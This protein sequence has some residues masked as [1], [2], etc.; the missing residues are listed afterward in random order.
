MNRQF[1]LNIALLLGI[2]G[3]IKPLYLFGI[4][5]TIQ[6]TLPEGDYGLY[7]TLFN[8]SFVLSIIN[9]PGIQNF[10][11]TYIAG[12]KHL[13]QKTFASTIQIRMLSGIL[14]L[15]A[16][17]I[18]GIFL[19]YHYDALLLLLLI[20]FNHFLAALA[21][22]FRANLSAIGHF[23]LDSIL[24]GLD[25]FLMIV[26]L[27]FFLTNPNLQPYLNIYWFVGL[28]GVAFLTTLLIALFFVLQNTASLRKPNWRISYVFLKKS[29]PYALVVFL[30]LSY[31]RV[32]AIMIERMLPSGKIEAGYYAAGYRLLDAVNAIGFL[33]SAL[34]LPMFAQL[35]TQKKP[36]TP[37]IQLSLNHVIALAGWISMILITYS[38]PIIQTLY[39]NLPPSV[40][41]ILQYLMLTF[42]CLAIGYVFGT[43]LTATGNIQKMNGLFA[44]AAITNIGLNRYWIPLEKSIGAAKATLV[45]QIFVCLALIIMANHWLKLKFTFKLW[46]KPILYLVLLTLIGYTIQYL[47]LSLVLGIL[48][49]GFAALSISVV[50]GLI[51][52]F[53]WSKN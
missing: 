19:G 50:L 31:T 5:R 22:F 33:F 20:A 52:P 51:Q 29:L 9:D 1:S 7:F 34:L 46:G 47:K 15:L 32:D 6:N 53:N 48:S 3:L 37:L 13:L 42:I 40:P 12:K 16:I 38:N 45:T 23:T 11:T 2:N 30:M 10:N 28:Q 35:Y 49:S 4:D 8:L 17:L 39:P 25:K 21:L 18:I 44:I 36:L 27:G 43:L 24:S 26:L 41:I 14:F